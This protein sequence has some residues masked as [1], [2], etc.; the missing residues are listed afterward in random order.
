MTFLWTLLWKFPFSFNWSLGFPCSSIPLEIP[1]LPYPCHLFGS[2]FSGISHCFCY[3]F[4]FYWVA[5]LSKWLQPV[6]LIYGRFKHIQNGKYWDLNFLTSVFQAGNPE[7]TYQKRRL[8]CAVTQVVLVKNSWKTHKYKFNFYI[9]FKIINIHN[10]SWKKLFFLA[11]LNPLFHYCNLKIFNWPCTIHKI[12]YS[13]QNL[14]FLLNKAS[15]NPVW[16]GRHIK[17]QFKV[18]SARF[19]HISCVP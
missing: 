4:I 1:C 12:V 2:D 19:K 5:T 16:V 7:K 6:F 10:R 17:K 18:V 15:N 13:H 8:Q 14:F 11:L 9:I 3:V